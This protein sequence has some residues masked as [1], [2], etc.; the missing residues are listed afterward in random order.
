MIDR[1]IDDNA[2]RCPFCSRLLDSPGEITSRFGSSFE[3]GRC[4]CGAVF[5]YDRGGHSL[6]DAYVDALGLLCEDDWDRAWSL[7]PGEDYEVVERGYDSRR[8]RFG[9]EP[10]RRSN[11][12]V[13]LFLRLKEKG[14]SVNHG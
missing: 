1:Q 8:K 13:F 4:D 2:F 7:V 11:S 10:K 6:G 3:G 14:A 5:I 12:P 9:G